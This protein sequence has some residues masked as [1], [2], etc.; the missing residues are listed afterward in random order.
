MSVVLSDELVEFVESGLSI[1]VGTRDA[2]NRPECQRVMGASVGADR[3]SVS[4]YLNR[5]LADRTLANLD[6]NR[7]IAA[8]FTRPVDHRSV[9]IKGTLTE[10]HVGTDVDRAL[11][12]RYLA[13]FVEQLYCVMIPRAVTRRMRLWPSVVVTF[14]VEGL[15]MQTPGPAA[16]ARLTRFT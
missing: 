4:L 5:V 10:W 7:Q 12:E 14:A 8:F 11:Q 13:G 9:Q 16:G 1:S 2:L 6:D 15:F 3:K